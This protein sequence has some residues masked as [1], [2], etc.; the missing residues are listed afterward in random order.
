MTEFSAET[1]RVLRS[2][3]WEPDRTVDTSLWR[4]RL[5]ESGFRM[6]DAAERFLSEF[7]GLT[8]EISGPGV[9]RARVPFEL[10]P[11][12]A[13]GEEDRFS[14]W[15]ESIG[16]SLFPLGELDRGRFFLGIS[17]SGKVYLVADW[18][19]SFGP[20]REALERLVRGIAPDELPEQLGVKGSQVQILS[21]RPAFSQVVGRFHREVGAA[22]T[23]F[24]GLVSAL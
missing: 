13:D 7:G 20:S 24:P 2:A 6:H 10:D 4:Q 15:S 23:R 11:M 21:S 22:L 16:E 3:G 14:E 5:E 17:E 19:A 12:L 1:E 18:L 9:S 8:V